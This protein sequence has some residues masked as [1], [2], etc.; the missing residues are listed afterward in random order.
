MTNFPQQVDTISNL[1]SATNNAKSFLASPIDAINPTPTIVLASDTKFPTSRTTITIDGEIFVCTRTAPNTFTVEL[2]G[3]FGTPIGSHTTLA[4]CYGMSIAEYHN[5]V[6]DAIIATQTFSANWWRK[7]IIDAV[8]TSPII[9]LSAGDCYIVTGLGGDWGTATVNDIAYVAQIGSPIVWQFIT[10]EDGMTTINLTTNEVWIYDGASWTAINSGTPLAIP[11]TTM[12]RD[13]NADTAVH[14]LETD[15][16]AIGS[17]ALIRYPG[18][19]A[20][21]HGRFSNTGD[22]QANK[23]I[24]RNITA[25][26]SF[27]ELF[28]DGA[29]GTQRLVLQDDSTWSFSIQITGHRTN[30]SDGHAGYIASGVIYRGA[31]AAST[32]LQGKP[33]IQV[34][35]ESD[36]AW[37]INIQADTTNGSLKITVKGENGKI[38]RWV[39]A[40]DTVEITN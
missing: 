2:R 5:D 24:V 32:S 35:S 36:K 11:N 8:N 17:Q 3:A 30:G 34:L 18:T 28:L 13:S 39:A 26:D 7:P 12:S 1:W 10:P 27:L 38:I 20:V 19:V 14:H 22:A 25:N 33:T 29:T 4:T 9:G 40:V 23:Y 15:S 37:D 21:A 31:G 6:R 16:I